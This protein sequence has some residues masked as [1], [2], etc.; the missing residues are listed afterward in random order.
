MSKILVWDTESTDLYA[1]WGRLLCFTW[2][3]A[4]EKKPHIIKITD[5][6]NFKKDCTDD[7]AL[8][9]D[10][11]KILSG[12]DM[13]FTWYGARHDI[14]L[15]NTRALKHGYTTL[16]PVPHVDGWRVSKY[17]LRLPSNRLQMVSSFFGLN[18]KTP[19]D[20][21]QW[22]RARAG[23]RPSLEYV[24]AHGLQDVVVTRDVYNV[25]RPL[26]TDHPNVGVMNGITDGCSVCGVKGK[27]QKR[28]RS[29]SNRRIR[30]RY[31]CQNCGAWSRGRS[32]T[33]DQWKEAV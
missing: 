9:K 23:H 6:P 13:W 25:V 2:M 15:I 3:E 5:Y 17:K 32:L 18:E 8:V 4:G 20:A 24:Y 33:F 21:D 16:P 7:S 14:P 27:M 30:Q 12:A 26:V 19:L 31:Q 29:I 1:T 10:T 22:A 28:G 11:I